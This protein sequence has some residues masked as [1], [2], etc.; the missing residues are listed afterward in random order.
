M[1]GIVRYNF[2]GDS[3]NSIQVA[4][5]AATVDLLVSSAMRQFEQ[6]PR[7][8]LAGEYLD[9]ELEDAKKRAE[10]LG[11]IGIATM[12]FSQSDLPDNTMLRKLNIIRPVNGEEDFMDV[13]SNPDSST[14]STGI[15]ISSR[16][17]LDYPFSSEVWRDNSLRGKSYAAM[18]DE[19]GEFA[20]EITQNPEAQSE[21]YMKCL[22][23]FIQQYL[24]DPDLRA[25]HD[26]GIMTCLTDVKNGIPLSLGQNHNLHTGHL[27]LE[28]T[29]FYK[30]GWTNVSSMGSITKKLI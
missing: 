17:R 29:P 9:T 4:N 14:V 6:G 26:R 28:G 27:Q 7:E 24:Q 15:A 12:E 10:L 19:H 22:R 13:L 5:N 23:R 21:Y 16:N 1:S 25:Q 8:K 3:N 2:A 18:V 11:I 20:N 30:S